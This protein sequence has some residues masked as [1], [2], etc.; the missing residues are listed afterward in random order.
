MTLTCSGEGSH[1]LCCDPARLALLVVLAEQHVT[2]V[3]YTS[4]QGEHLLLRVLVDVYTIQTQ[5]CAGEVIIV[6]DFGQVRV[7]V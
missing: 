7:A 1:R 5:H 4:E 3:Q 6:A 2:E